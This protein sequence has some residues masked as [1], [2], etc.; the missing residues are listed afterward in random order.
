MRCDMYT[1]YSK[2]H[3]QVLKN[4]YHRAEYPCT[5]NRAITTNKDQ[6]PYHVVN[7]NSYWSTQ[8][9]RCRCVRKFQN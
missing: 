8:I 1:P 2:K 9:E 4:N 5:W 6:L 3:F 7:P